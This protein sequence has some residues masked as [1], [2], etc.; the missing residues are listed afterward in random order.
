MTRTNDPDL[1]VKSAQRAGDPPAEPPALLLYS[2]RPMFLAAGSW[3]IIALALWLAMFLGYVQLPTRFD[4]VSWHIHEMLFGFVMAAVTGF[5]LTAIPNWTGR[6]PVRGFRLAA[7]AALWLL[8]RIACLISAGLPGWLAVAIDV[9]FPLVLLLVA[10]REIVAGRNWRN[11]MMTAPLAVLAIADL[12]MHLESLGLSVPSGLGWRLGLA[13]PI[14]LVSV[15]GGRIIPSFTRNWLVKRQSARLPSALG[16]FDAVCLVAIAAAFILWAFLPDGPLTGAFLVAAALLHA[17]R[18][19]RWAGFATWPEPLLFI[20]HAGYGWMVAGAALLGLSEFDIGVP[21]S[22][23]IH[24]LTAGALAVMILAVMPRVTL[25][26]TGRTLAANPVTVLIFVLINGAALMRVLASWDVGLFVPL[27]L[28]AGGLW[29]AAFALFE[30]A[31][32]PML[33][34]QKP[35]P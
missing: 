15:I 4:P 12:L 23:A 31:Y 18:L 35:K 20:L 10:A 17:L 1:G 6:L 11:L 5:V 30:L 2:F 8:G 25:G 13:A 33:L 16:R 7:L 21:T 28:V 14:V 3:A 29:I 26:H 34:T 19:G 27:L 9:A 32:G 24:A 22:A